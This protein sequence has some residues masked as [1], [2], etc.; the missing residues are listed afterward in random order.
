[1][2]IYNISQTNYQPQI[3]NQKP[4]FGAKIKIDLN[5]KLLHDIDSRELDYGFW[6]LISRRPLRR[7]MQKLEQIHPDHTVEFTYEKPIFYGYNYVKGNGFAQSDAKIRATNITTG[8]FESISIPDSN[9]YPF[10]ELVSSI[11][12]SK[13]FWLK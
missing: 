6:G 10:Y 12:N 1:M 4:S 11:L 7:A 9:A 8:K 3:N 2:K 5:T 13:Y